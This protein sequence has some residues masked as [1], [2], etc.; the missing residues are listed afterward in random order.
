MS[1]KIRYLFSLLAGILAGLSLLWLL[2][3][4]A[5]PKTNTVVVSNVAAG[6]STTTQGQTAA[7]ATSTPAATPTPEPTPLPPATPPA[8]IG[9]E[10]LALGDSV[11]YGV[12]APVPN[13]QGYAGIF[14]A[15]YLK[16]IQPEI[17]VYRNM[18]IPGETSQSFI[19]GSKGQ[20]QLQNA[21]NELDAAAGAGRKISPI[22]LT[23]GGNDMLGARGKPNSERETALSRFDQNLNR[24]LS[25][26][27]SKAG[28]ADIIVTTYYNPYAFS[29]GG[30]DTETAWV[31]RFDDVIRKRAGEHNAKVAD[32][33]TPIAGHE[34]N[35]TWITFGDVHPTL[36][37]HSLL[38]QAVWK[39][40]GYD[41][42]APLLKLTYSPLAPDRVVAGSNRLP[43]KFSA[44]ENWAETLLNG[45][46]DSDV[47]GAGVL[48][49]ADA[50]VD[51]GNKVSLAAVPTRLSNVPADAREYS[52]ILDTGLLASGP[53]TL[54]FEVSDT[55]GNVGTLDVK[56]EVD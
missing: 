27:R 45:A 31:K 16:R 32:F 20:S 55:A 51:N 30:D 54:R 37:G 14:Y 40:S 48:L 3:A 43:F 22:T 28:Q 5:A 29:T 19:D 18:A 52:Y 46:A 42:T 41:T 23:I 15:N 25:A 34:R 39:A 33:Y 12:G 56:F 36:T 47:A 4:N 10:Y 26:L 7:V 17:L 49:S 11:A 50:V 53:H 8:S 1:K 21:L 35:L 24:I 44:Q 9:G 38:A 6:A 13:Q 2:G